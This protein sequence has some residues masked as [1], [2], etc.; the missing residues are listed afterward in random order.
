M[1]PGTTTSSGGTEKRMVVALDDRSGDAL[2][3]RCT[4]HGSDPA[5]AAGADR[6]RHRRDDRVDVRPGDVAGPAARRVRGGPRRPARSGRLREHSGS[7]TTA[8]AR[9]TCGACSRRWPSDGLRGGRHRRLLPRRERDAQ[10]PGRAAG[11]HPGARGVAVSAP[12]D[13]TSAT[14]TSGA[15]FGL[16]EPSWRPDQA[17]T[18]GPGS[19]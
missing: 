15:M 6:A 17:D 19:C 14:S 2:A 10:A 3:V 18:A 12:L 9:R 8:D 5:A 4:S 11:G 1:R 13:L 16:Y 7:C